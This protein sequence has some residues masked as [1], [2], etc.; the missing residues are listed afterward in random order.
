MGIAKKLGKLGASIAVTAMAGI[1]AA[2]IPARDLARG[3]HYP[4]C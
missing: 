2:E 4:F 3:A 1:A